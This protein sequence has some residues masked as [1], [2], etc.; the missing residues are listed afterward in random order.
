MQMQED[1]A[2]ST[3]KSHGQM[4]DLN[5]GPSCSEAVCP[6]ICQEDLTCSRYFNRLPA[7]A[8]VPR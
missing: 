2:N 5:L 3:Q 1:H 6:M 8:S 7:T 4:V